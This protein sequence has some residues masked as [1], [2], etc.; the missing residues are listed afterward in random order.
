MTYIMVDIESDGPAPGLYSMIAIGA[1]D[2]SDF[3]NNFL[4]YLAPITGKYVPEALAVS[5]FSRKEVWEFPEAEI[6]M[7]RFGDWLSSFKKPIFISDNNGFDWSF[8]NYYLHRFY[9][10]N[11]FGFSSRNMNDL[12]KGYTNDMYASFKSFRKTKHDHNPLNDAI[13]NA[14]AL[15]EMKR[16]GLRINI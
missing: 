3:N 13:G 9:G 11:P 8:V 4:G 16:R 7:Q 15:L 6:T 1:V 5:G 12:Y 14:E 10:K 2:V